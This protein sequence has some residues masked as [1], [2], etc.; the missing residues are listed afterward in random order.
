MVA[1]LVGILLLSKRH[2]TSNQEKSIREVSD[3]LIKAD[4]FDQR[5]F[6]DIRLFWNFAIY[7]CV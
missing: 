1:L 3:S 2:L 5:D 4:R 7:E 6:V